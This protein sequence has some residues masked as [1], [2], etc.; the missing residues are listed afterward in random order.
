MGRKL[1][2]RVGKVFGLV[3]V[4]SRAENDVDGKARWN[5]VCTCGVRRLMRGDDLNARAPKTHVA[6]KKAKWAEREKVLRA[7]RNR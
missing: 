6:C 4:E 5:V 3:T 7:E 2:D 1:I